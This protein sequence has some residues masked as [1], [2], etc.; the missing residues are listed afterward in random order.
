MFNL[1]KSFINFIVLS[2]GQTSSLR[3][4]QCLII[5][6]FKVKL[7][8]Q[9]EMTIHGLRIIIIIIAFLKRHLHCCMNIPKH[10]ENCTLWWEECTVT[11]IDTFIKIFVTGKPGDEYGLTPDFLNNLDTL[12]DTFDCLV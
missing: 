7:I 2:N 3:L 12:I 10:F 5:K 1:I 11:I 4:G 8:T 6:N 9:N